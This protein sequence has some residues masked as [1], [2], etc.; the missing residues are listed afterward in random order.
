MNLQPSNAY[1]QNYIPSLKESDIFLI[2]KALNEKDLAFFIRYFWKY[3]DPAPYVDGWHIHAICEHL[4][5]VTSGEITRLIITMPPRHMKSITVSVAWP[6]WAWTKQPEKQFLTSSYALSLATRD[7]VKSRRIIES[8]LYQ[9][10]WGDKFNLAYDQNAKTKYENNHMGHRL[11]TSVGGSTTGEGGDYV[12]I[13][14]P[15]NVISVESDIKR[16][17]A[18]DWW[19]GSMSTR[20]NNAITGSFVIVGQRTHH[21]DLIGHILKNESGWEHLNL[22][23]EYEPSKKCVTVLGWEDPRNE[24][25][26][27]LWPDKFPQK[28]LDE[29]KERLGTYGAAAQLQQQPTPQTGGLIP[30]D[31]F[32]YISE[33]PFTIMTI[34]G[35]DTAF[36]EGTLNDYSVCQTWLLCE[37]GYVLWDLWHKRVAY[38]ILKESAKSLYASSGASGVLIE[39]KASGQSLIQDLKNTTI[40]IIAINPGDRDKVTRL[41]AVSPVI[42]AGKVYIREG[43]PWLADF[44]AECMEFPRGDHDDQVDVMTECLEY[45]RKSNIGTDNI[46]GAD[47]IASEGA[48]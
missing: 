1:T 40:P 22:P 27:L 37:F 29:M 7:A 15:H 36:K 43:Q 30:I 13:D 41:I 16:E 33:K 6:A 39:D 47:S 2:D 18:I 8:P 45:L 12:L 4:E 38:P 14:D 25:K 32:K 5:A 23:A 31:K 42:D 10:M 20:L 35:W 11:I 26:E 17:G 34:Q 3:I 28:E 19:K 9:Q 48:W 46:Q 21:N 44:L 24:D